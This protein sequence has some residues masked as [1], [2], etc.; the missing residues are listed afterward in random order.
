MPSLVSVL[1]GEVLSRVLTPENAVIT[2]RLESLV[3]LIIRTVK[4]SIPFQ[5]GI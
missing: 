1:V 4:R 5:F 2:P 3:S